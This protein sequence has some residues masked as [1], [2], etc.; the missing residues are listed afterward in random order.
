L[1]KAFSPNNTK[2]GFLATGI[3]PLNCHV[4]DKHLIPSNTYRSNVGQGGGLDAQAHTTNSYE[5][6]EVG[7]QSDDE[8]EEVEARVFHCGSNAGGG[9]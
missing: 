7:G 6:S 8:P 1:E 4:V 9:Y 3:F 2:K 5:N